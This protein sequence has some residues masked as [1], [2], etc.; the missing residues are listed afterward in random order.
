MNVYTLK[1]KSNADCN[2]YI[3]DQF[4]ANAKRNQIEKVSLEEGEY[5]VRGESLNNPNEVITQIVSLNQHKI[6]ELKFAVS[7]ISQDMSD[8]K[9]DKHDLN[10]ITDSPVPKKRVSSEHSTKINEVVESLK[11]NAEKNKSNKEQKGKRED[12]KTIKGVNVPVTS[13][14]NGNNY[15]IPNIIWRIILSVGLFAIILV[16]IPTVIG[17]PISIM[18]AKPGFESIWK[19]DC[20][21]F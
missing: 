18:I 14:S 12:H 13:V 15:N 17:T 9:S 19:G 2:I 10:D 4:Q 16:L 21:I 8:A 20:D 3:D 6:I 11:A 1:I 7:A 5:W